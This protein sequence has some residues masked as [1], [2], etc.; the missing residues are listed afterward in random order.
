MVQVEFKDMSGQILGQA[1]GGCRQH[2]IGGDAPCRGRVATAAAHG[3]AEGLAHLREA[4]GDRLD[5]GT[6]R[7]L[8]HLR[9]I[10][11][12]G[13]FHRGGQVD[14]TA[15]VVRP[16]EE[17]E[18]LLGAVAADQPGRHPRTV[19]GRLGGLHLDRDHTW[20]GMRP[21]R[22][23]FAAGRMDLGHGCV[24]VAGRARCHETRHAA[25][26]AAVSAIGAGDG[27]GH[28]KLLGWRG[29]CATCLVWAEDQAQGW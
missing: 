13:R 5:R 22:Q 17:D 8:D 11:A 16:D 9:R 21:T 18:A 26:W 25:G 15:L 27:E 24:G 1:G 19:F 4:L 29:R 23:P 6:Q 14:A 28:G 3:L 2:R 20:R 7:L 10:A 12:E